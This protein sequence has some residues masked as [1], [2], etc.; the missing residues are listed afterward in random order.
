MLNHHVPLCVGYSLLTSSE[1]KYFVWKWSIGKIG[2]MYHFAKTRIFVTL[3][4]NLYIEVIQKISS[5]LSSSEMLKN[6]QVSKMR[7]SNA[8]TSFLPATKTDI[9][10]IN[11]LLKCH[12]LFSKEIWLTGHIIWWPNFHKKTYKQQDVSF[13]TFYSRKCHSL[14][15]KFV[16][17]VSFFCTGV[18]CT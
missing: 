7:K 8:Y 17:K 9:F 13:K 3:V 18:I 14:K 11:L 6:R 15:K 4:S 1:Y 16:T 2:K 12:F 5:I 10:I